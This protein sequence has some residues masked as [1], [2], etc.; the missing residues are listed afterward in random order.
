M[1]IDIFLQNCHYYLSVS[2]NTNFPKLLIPEV[3]FLGRSNVGKSSLLNSLLHR[4][5]LV[6]TSNTPGSTVKINFFNL[7]DQLILVDLPGYGYIRRSKELALSL[8]ALVQKYFCNRENLRI[9]VLMIDSR[10]GIQK[11]DELLLTF[12]GSKNI[13]I[14]LVFNKIDKLNSREL[15]SLISDDL[16]NKTYPPSVKSTIFTSCVKKI[17]VKKLRQTI[18]QIMNQL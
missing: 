15:E 16:S 3:G 5:N 13:N 9:L 8:N 14:I 7:S 17:G 2:K 1:N 12:L 6:R 10:R 18:I 11:E 4:K